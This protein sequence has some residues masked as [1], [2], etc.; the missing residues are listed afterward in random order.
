MDL[1]WIG[2][3]PCTEKHKCMETPFLSET[4]F[5]PGG[6]LFDPSIKP[7]FQVA[8]GVVSGAMPGKDV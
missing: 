2:F 7:L 8:E 1:V 4:V 5:E 6:K 3:L